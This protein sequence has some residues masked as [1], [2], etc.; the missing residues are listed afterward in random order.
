MNAAPKVNS[1]LFSLIASTGRVEERGIFVNRDGT[2]VVVAAAQECG[3]E[4][5]LKFK[6]RAEDDVALSTT[7]VFHLDPHHTC[8][9]DAVKEINLHLEASPLR[10]FKDLDLTVQIGVKPATPENLGGGMDYLMGLVWGLV[11]LI[12][13]A[14]EDP[15]PQTNPKEVVRIFLAYVAQC[16]FLHQFL[17]EHSDAENGVLN[18]TFGQEARATARVN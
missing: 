9:I 6:L 8:I 11:H 3:P 7:T 17:V 4:V 2:E 12:P 18:E 15:E 13:Q 1:N 14:L 5:T 10:L 16:P